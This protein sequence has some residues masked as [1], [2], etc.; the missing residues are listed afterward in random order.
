[1]THAACGHLAP[2]AG[3]GMCAA[4]Y[5]AWEARYLAANPAPRDLGSAA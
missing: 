3:A 5:A 1:V 4:C 2:T